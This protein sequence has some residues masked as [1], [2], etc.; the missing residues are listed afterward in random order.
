VA[1]AFIAMWRCG[2]QAEEGATRRPSVCVG[3]GGR[4][5]PDRQATSGRQWPSRG[6]HVWAVHGHAIGAEQGRAGVADLWVPD[7][8]PGGDG[9]NLFQI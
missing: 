6:A 7:R 8:V 9:L 1:A 3:G 2:G 4:S 5:W